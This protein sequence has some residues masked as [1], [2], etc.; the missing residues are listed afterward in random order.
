MPS[1]FVMTLPVLISLPAAAIVSTVPMG[2]AAFTS[3]LPV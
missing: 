2:S 1:S 3:A